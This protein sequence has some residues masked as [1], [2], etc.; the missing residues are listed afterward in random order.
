MFAQGIF[1]DKVYELY[2]KKKQ[3]RIN[4]FSDTF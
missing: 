3:Q 4:T 1:P 2:K